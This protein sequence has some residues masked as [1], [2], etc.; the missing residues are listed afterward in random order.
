MGDPAP[1]KVEADRAGW[2]VRDYFPDGVAPAS[3]IVLDGDGT[4]VGFE[5]GSSSF[6]TGINMASATIAGDDIVLSASGVIMAATSI[7]FEIAGTS[8]LAIT[9]SGIKLDATVTL[10]DDGTIAD[11]SNIMTVT[12]NT[13]KLVGDTAITLDGD[14]ALDGAHTFT[15]GTGTVSLNGDVTVA[16]GKTLYIRDASQSIASASDDLMTLTSPTLTLAGATKINLDGPTDVTGILTIDT[17]GSPADG[18]KISAT[19][20]ADGLEISSA[21]SANGINISGTC[22]T[23]ISMT[24]ASTVGLKISAGPM[25]FDL[26]STLPAGAAVNANEIN[27]TDNSTGS[28]GYARALWINAVIAGDKTGTGEHNSFAIDQHITGNAPY[29]YGMTFYSYDTGDPTI[30]FA[31]PISIYQDDLGTSLGAW[32][33]IDIGSNFTNAPA[34]RHTFFRCRN[35]N[36]AAVPNCIIQC[37]GSAGATYLLDI[38]TVA[39]M[40]STTSGATTPTHKIAVNTP[41]G[42][43][44]VKLFSDS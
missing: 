25:G 34:G 9:A 11:A 40:L 2:F 26:T 7:G 29:L 30:G 39:N 21:C 13:I 41:A 27:V 37:E 5:F 20:P 36:A 33:G 28:S 3:K 31:A 12:Q 10:D 18:V 42:V 23:G 15:T 6:T 43:R 1:G 22:V 19:T 44:Y 4:G 38:D 17:A 8:K 16:T 14:T 35:H 32:V 24:N